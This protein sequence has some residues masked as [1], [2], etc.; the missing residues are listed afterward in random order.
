MFAVS[1]H[2]ILHTPYAILAPMWIIAGLGNPD[3]QYE[4]SR[5]NAGRDLLCAIAKK[6]GI[7][8][9]KADKKTRSQLVKGELF[10]EKVTLLL[11]DTYMNNSGG[12]LKPLIGSAKAAQKLIVLHDDLDLPLGAVKLSFGSGSGG[13]KGIESIQKALKTRDFIRIRIGISPSTAS[14][15]IRKPDSEKT[16]DYVLGAFKSGE[17]EKLKKVRKTVAEALELILTEGLERAT[18]VIHSRR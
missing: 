6:E 7:T 16:I 12:A 15:K 4:G 18:M 13:H 1:P 5:H 2:L 14:G 11:P 17:S 10:G 3:E 9:W 8:D